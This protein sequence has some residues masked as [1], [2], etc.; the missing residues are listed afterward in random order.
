ML[1]ITDITYAANNPTVEFFVSNNR[2]EIGVEKAYERLVSKAQH[3]LKDCTIDV[4]QKNHIEQGRFENI[5]GTYEMTSDKN[6]TGDNTE[7]FRASSLQ[8]I[9]QNQILSLASELAKTFQ[10]E[11]IAV[12]IPSDQST[13][14][15]I[16]VNFTSH[17]PNIIE[18]I[19]LVHEQLPAYAT[20]FSLHLNH[21]DSGFNNAKVTQIEWLGSKIAINEI[22]TAFPQES[23][24]YN[25][26]QAYLVYQNGHEEQL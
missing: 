23:I 3:D 9:S 21:A 19:K 8:N 13:I 14:A 4:L 24:S 1:G 6:I 15:D 12:F 5:L 22:K 2:H 7:I 10:Q 17:Q 11:S 18:T 25:Y 16:V 20:S 26:G